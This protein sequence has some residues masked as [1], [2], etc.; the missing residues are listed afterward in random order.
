[1]KEMQE[2]ADLGLHGAL[3]MLSVTSNELR[4]VNFTHV[5]AAC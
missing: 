3:R 2:V 5:Y 1:M 4:E